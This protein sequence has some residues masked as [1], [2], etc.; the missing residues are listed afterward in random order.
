MENETLRRETGDMHAHLAMMQV[1]QSDMMQQIAHLQDN[2]GEVVRE[3]AETKRRLGVQQQVIKN[4]M[5]H[6]QQTSGQRGCDGDIW[7]MTNLQPFRFKCHLTRTRSRLRIQIVLQFTLH[8]PTNNITTIKVALLSFYI[9]RRRIWP[10]Q[11]L[12]QLQQPVQSDMRIVR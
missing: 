12:R 8:L 2:F 7:I 4:M 6:M 9:L 3:L 11:L 10:R 1:T 5:D